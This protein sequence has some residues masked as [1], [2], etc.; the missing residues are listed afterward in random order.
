M[1]HSQ[2]ENDLLP[3]KITS[4]S[5]I[6]PNVFMISWKRI[7]SFIPGQVVK[8]TF[9]FETP[10]RIYSICSGSHDENMSILFDLKQDGVLTP[11]LAKTQPG[12]NIFV[13][14]PYGS[15]TC[16]SLPA[17][18]IATGTGIAP[19]YSMFRSGLAKDKILIHG[20][21]YLNLFHFS[22]EFEVSL[23]DKYIRY[24]SSEEASGVFRGRITD[25][26]AKSN[27]LPL[28]FKY[29]LCGGGLMVVEVRDLLIEKGIPFDNILS[30]IYF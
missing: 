8:I 21:R 23:G 3:V 14:N 10:P 7:G 18:W 6:S 29:Y 22:E 24:C 1:S 30:E 20:A 17:F 19:F 11:M 26:I 5:E 12:S 25:F 2:S 27:E 16:D 28:D 15:F 4:N 13:S 9:D